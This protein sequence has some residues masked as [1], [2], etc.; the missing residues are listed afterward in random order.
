MIKHRLAI[1]VMLAPLALAGAARAQFDL[2]YN[3]SNTTGFT[4]SQ[5]AIIQ[6]AITAAEA[7]WEAKITG[8]QPGIVQPT[9]PITVS[10]SLMGGVA[11]GGP[12]VR[13]WQG[14]F[15]VVETGQI[16]IEPTQ[17]LPLWDWNG[18]GLNLWNAILAHESLHALGFGTT[19]VENGVYVNGIG[20][21]TGAAGLAAYQE[22]FEPSAT[23]I[24]V[25]L[26]AGREDSHWDQI[27]RS[28]PDE[29]FPSDPFSISPLLGITDAQGR[30]LALELM[31]AA[32]DPDYGEPF[33]S[34]TTVYSLR[35]LGF[36]TVPE[37]AAGQVLFSAGLFLW[38]WRRHNQPRRHALSGLRPSARRQSAACPA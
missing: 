35:D 32:L 28:D 10:R 29:G 17:V 20:E 9:V 31:T 27:V 36:T 2:V 21:Y 5:V 37:P 24:P 23:F 38:P 30:D 26:A 34:K 13:D 16:L 1:L 11:F 7:L 19:W 33:L 15:Y 4:A 25:E 8:Y 6:N 14:G 18:T 3:F 12:L 22:E